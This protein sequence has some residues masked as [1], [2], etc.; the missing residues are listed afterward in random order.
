[1]G[2]EGCEKATEHGRSQ[3]KKKAWKKRTMKAGCDGEQDGNGS[4]LQ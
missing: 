4:W 1:M 2:T 3:L